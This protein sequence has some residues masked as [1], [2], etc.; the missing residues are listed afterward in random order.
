MNTPTAIPDTH[1]KTQWQTEIDKN[2]LKMQAIDIKWHHHHPATSDI[3]TGN[4]RHTK[5]SLTYKR[6]TT[7]ATNMMNMTHSDKPIGKSQ[8]KMTANT[9]T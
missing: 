5:A 9:L 1:G 3:H 8:P 4:P 6:N 2:N 7:P